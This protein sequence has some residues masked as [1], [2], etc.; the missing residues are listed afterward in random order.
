MKKRFSYLF[1]PILALAGGGLSWLFSRKGLAE[2]YP[3][4]Q[5]SALTPPDWVFPL[6]WSILYILMGLGLAM[7]LQRNSPDT[8][9]VGA[10]WFLQLAA[11]LLWSPLF[12]RWQ[13]FL[14]ALIDLA[15]LWL[16]ILAMT[17]LFARISK[18]AALLQIP[19]LLWVGFAGY[20]NYVVWQLN[21]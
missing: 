2:A 14:A 17:A 3:L 4:L 16:L 9:G 5:K 1:W 7:V 6:V 20:L 12:F 11:N 15:V 18:T 13:L 21:P 19:Y 10:V 8:Q